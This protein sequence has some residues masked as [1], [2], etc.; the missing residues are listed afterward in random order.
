[1]RTSRSE[2]GW[3][4]RFELEFTVGMVIGAPVGYPIE[5]SIIMLLEL[6]LGNYFGTWERSLVG[7]SL[8]TLTGLM[9]GTGEVS[10]VGL[11][12]GLPLGSLLESPN[13]GAYMPGTLLGVPLGLWFGY[14]VV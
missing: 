3:A 8:D 5:Y 11:S 14:V 4:L 2:I 12:L 13:N 9:I 6:A 10:L 1:M 7:V